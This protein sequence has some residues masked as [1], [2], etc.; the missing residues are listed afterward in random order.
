MLK[1]I[2]KDE[3]LRYWLFQNEKN[4][5]EEREGGKSLSQGEMK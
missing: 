1:Y 2:H 4:L 3:T 5:A